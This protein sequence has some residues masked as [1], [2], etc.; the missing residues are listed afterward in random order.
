MTDQA[1]PAPD[2]PDDRVRDDIARHGWHL[3]LVPPEAKSPGWAHTLGLLER[4]DHPELLCFGIDLQVLARLLNHLGEAVR[5]GRRFEAGS[6]EEDL[7]E[8]GR[9]AFRTVQA[10]WFQAF[11]G[12]AAWHYRRESFPA[13]QCFWP[14]PSGHF[15]W[16]E[17]GDPSWRGDQPLLYQRDTARALPE[18]LLD[19]LRREG[20]LG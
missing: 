15:P 14:D 18:P 2:S 10:K 16:E 17:D 7:L 5:R 1:P 20:A 9:L 19:A 11:L 3:V 4:F 6:E 12:N 8:G 13:L